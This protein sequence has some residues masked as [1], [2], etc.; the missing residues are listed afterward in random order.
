M[1]ELFEHICDNLCKRFLLEEYELVPN[2]RR[3]RWKMLDKYEI[4]EG[5][6]V[7]IE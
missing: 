7:K 3:F 1:K 2:D 4:D 6:I 5:K